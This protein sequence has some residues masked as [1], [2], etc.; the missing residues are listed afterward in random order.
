MGL[1]KFKHI[2]RP[3]EIPEQPDAGT[4][5]SMDVLAHEAYKAAFD[6]YLAQLTERFPADKGS[7]YEWGKH[8]RQVDFAKEYDRY[9]EREPYKQWSYCVTNAEIRLMPEWRM[10]VYDFARQHGYTRSMHDFSVGTRRK[11]GR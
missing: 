8:P 1:T 2:K 3:E 9:V 4:S 10:M 5:L 7:V 11:L 6:K